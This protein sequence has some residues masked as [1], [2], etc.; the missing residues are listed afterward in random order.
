M[1]VRLK[2]KLGDVEDYKL[3]MGWRDWLLLQR[4]QIQFPT[5]T[6]QLTDVHNPN[7]NV[8]DAV[9]WPLQALGMHLVGRHT[10]RQNTHI[11]KTTKI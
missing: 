2:L 5:L 8:S 6:W 3:E 11:R 7:W 1:C 4:T 9:L 10:S